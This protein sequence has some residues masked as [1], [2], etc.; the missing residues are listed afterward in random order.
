MEGTASGNKFRNPYRHVTAIHNPFE[1]FGRVRFLENVYSLIDARQNV[2]ITG[3]RRIGKS[4]VLT[5]MGVPEFQRR[6]TDHDLSRH[7]FLLVNLEEFQPK[8]TE[9]FLTFVTKRFVQQIQNRVTLDILESD[10]AET[11][12]DLLDAMNTHVFIRSLAR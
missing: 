5:C 4:S 10:G 2:A 3:L 1:F 11:F 6:F 9:E 7:I 12:S 8:T